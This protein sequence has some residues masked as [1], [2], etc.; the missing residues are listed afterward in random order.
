[1]RQNGVI[2]LLVLSIPG[3]ALLNLAV[4]SV[5]IPLS[6]VMGILSGRGTEV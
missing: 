2:L 1:M 4:G 3:L 6:E 5:G